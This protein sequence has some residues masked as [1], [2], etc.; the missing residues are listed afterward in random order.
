MD[1]NIKNKKELGALGEK[2]AQAYL[3]ENGF[4]IIKKNYRSESGEI[5]IIASNKDWTIF[6][7]VKT[8]TGSAFGSPQESIDF[9]KVERIRK[10]AI[11]FL[12]D[13]MP[14]GKK[15]IRFDVASIIISRNKLEKLLN[16]DMGKEKLA[17][18]YKDFCSIEHI[19]D[20]F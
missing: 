1:M 14:E 11:A 15:S 9:S 19:P 13:N 3:K 8:R 6:V 7:E 10:A 18:R 2:I 5:D 4:T 17:G 16:Q 12:K 20:A